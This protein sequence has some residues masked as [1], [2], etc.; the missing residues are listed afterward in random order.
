MP[1][2][3]N[4]ST[5]LFR[6]TAT[7][8]ISCV[9]VLFLISRWSIEVSYYCLRGVYFSFQFFQCMLD[10]FW[11]SDV[12]CI[13]VY[14]YYIFL[15]NWYFCAVLSHSVTSNSLRPHGQ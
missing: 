13:Y 1:D 6:S 8:L 9:V 5:V 4:W 15:M 14:N 12:L 10:I 11:S 2:S 7:L 3:F